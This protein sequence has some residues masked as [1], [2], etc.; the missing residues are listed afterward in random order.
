MLVDN[1]VVGS[2]IGKGG[3]TI[4]KIS[5]ESGSSIQVQG[6]DEQ[7]PSQLE[8]RVTI[9][10]VSRV[11]FVAVKKRMCREWKGRGGRGFCD[12]G[13][14]GVAFVFTFSPPVNPIYCQVSMPMAHCCCSPAPL[15]VVAG[16]LC[17]LFLTC[18]PWSSFASLT[19]ASFLRQRDVVVEGVATKGPFLCRKIVRNPTVHVPEPTTLAP[20]FFFI[21]TG[22]HADPHESSEHDLRGPPERREA[23]RRRSRRER[24][25]R[26]W[27][28]SR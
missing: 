4:R 5:T 11:F 25:R 26:R 1:S 8:R 24:R 2:I 18:R 9:T 17:L 10:S 15:S 16:V 23:R 12:G 6:R 14:C 7:S 19:L 3:Q 22:R 28:R 13:G 27:R 20:L 21:W